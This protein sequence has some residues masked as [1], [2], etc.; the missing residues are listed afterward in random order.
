MRLT[1]VAAHTPADPKKRGNSMTTPRPSADEATRVLVVDDEPAIRQTLDA[2]LGAEG[3]LVEQAESG[4]EA[5]ERCRRAAFDI[6]VLDQS[7]PGMTGIEAARQLLAEPTHMRILIFSAYLS[8]GLRAE[9]EALG[10]T[11]VDKINWQELVLR[12]RALD[13]NQDRSADVAALSITA[14]GE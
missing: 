7:M 11:A 1:A 5:I 10:I 9:C 2:L 6:L 13:P 4:L 8:G 12:C 3:W 14:V